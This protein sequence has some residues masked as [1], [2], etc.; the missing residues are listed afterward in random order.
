[1]CF[2]TRVSPGVCISCLNCG[3][4]SYAGQRRARNARP[5]NCHQRAVH[6][7]VAPRV[8]SPVAR[9][10][11]TRHIHLSPPRRPRTLSF[12]MQKHIIMHTR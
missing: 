11:P 5:V 3:R 7:R 10:P 12:I 9:H 6:T 1:M 4:D 2:C 8:M